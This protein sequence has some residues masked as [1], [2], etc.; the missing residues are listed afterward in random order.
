MKIAEGT[1]NWGTGHAQGM[2]KHVG[3]WVGGDGNGRWQLRYVD[4]LGG[5]Q[6]AL[7]HMGDE[8]GPD[9]RV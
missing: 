7:A 4:V 6:E 2:Y 9:K 3:N 5:G 1:W 8:C